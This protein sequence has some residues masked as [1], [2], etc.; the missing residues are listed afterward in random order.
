MPFLKTVLERHKRC[1]QLRL[2]IIS[3]KVDL[4]SLYFK[5]EDKVDCEDKFSFMM[6]SSIMEGNLWFSNLH[7]LF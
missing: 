5:L 6:I 7:I 2:C 4:F 3:Q 1:K